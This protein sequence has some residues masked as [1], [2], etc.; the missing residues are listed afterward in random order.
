[1]PVKSKASSFIPSLSLGGYISGSGSDPESDI[2]VE[3]ARKNRRGQR[4]RQ[5][6]WEKKF[7]TGA[8]HL[9]KVKEDRNQGWDAKRGATDGVKGRRSERAQK[10]RTASGAGGSRGLAGKRGGAAGNSA[11]PRRKHNDDEGPLHPSWEAAKKAKEKKSVPV[12]FAGK[13]TTFD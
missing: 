4:A 2:D 1:V 11:A 8:K 3:P 7:G 6:I 5:Q 12:A 13:K 10:E 9:G